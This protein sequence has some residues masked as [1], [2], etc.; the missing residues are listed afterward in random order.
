MASVLSLVRQCLS[1]LSFIPIIIASN[2]SS[3][4]TSKMMEDDVDKGKEI[5]MQSDAGKEDGVRPMWMS[6][7]ELALWN[8]GAQV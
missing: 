7:L 5:A 2:N 1:V 6:A 3:S 4:S 8:F